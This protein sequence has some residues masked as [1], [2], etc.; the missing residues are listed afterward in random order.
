MDFDYQIAPALILLIAILII[1]LSLRRILSLRAKV[2]RNSGH[3]IQ[4]ER[5]DLIDKEVPLF[6]EQ[7]RGAIPPPTNYGSTTTE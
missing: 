4:T 7:I 6:I 3:Y 2:A 1:W 5:A